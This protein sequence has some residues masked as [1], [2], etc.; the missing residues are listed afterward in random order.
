LGKAANQPPL[1]GVEQVCVL[2][3]LLRFF[4]WRLSFRC[5]GDSAGEENAYYFVIVIPEN[6][7]KKRLFLGLNSLYLGSKWLFWG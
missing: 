7:V 1:H 3:A 2:A 6:P 4:A 5:E